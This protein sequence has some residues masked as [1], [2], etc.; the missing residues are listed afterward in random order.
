MLQ[1]KTFMNFL[2]NPRVQQ[3]QQKKK[4]KNQEQQT[5]VTGIIHTYFL[6]PVRGER[7]DKN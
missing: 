4:K 1:K 3:S 7:M 6:H 2:A 5:K